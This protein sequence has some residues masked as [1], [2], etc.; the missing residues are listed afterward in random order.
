MVELGILEKDA[1]ISSNSD[2]ADLLGMSDQGHIKNS[3][4]SDVLFVEENLLEDISKATE[5]TKH[6]MILK[7]ETPFYS[8]FN[9]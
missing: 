9:T 3:A 7:N 4:Y 6:R 5:P 1:L 2:S 8:N